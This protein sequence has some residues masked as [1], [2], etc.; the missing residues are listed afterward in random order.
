MYSHSLL[1]PVHYLAPSLTTCCEVKIKRRIKNKD[2]K[3]NK[4]KDKDKTEEKSENQSNDENKGEGERR[5]TYIS[6]YI[7]RES[8]AHRCD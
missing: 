7:E 2:K 5:D 8:A 1:H 4:K 6:I 3:K